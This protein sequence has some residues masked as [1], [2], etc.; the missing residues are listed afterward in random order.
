MIKCLLIILFSLSISPAFSNKNRL[1]LYRRVFEELNPYH[2]TQHKDS[3]VK[4]QSQNHLQFDYSWPAGSID[5]MTANYFYLSEF[6]SNA[7]ETPQQGLLTLE[8]LQGVSLQSFGYIKGKPLATPWAENCV[9]HP[10][11]SKQDAIRG[12]SLICLGQSKTFWI[13]SSYPLKVDWIERLYNE[14]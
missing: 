13:M 2:K 14:N 11:L 1:E 7:F 6:Q 4:Q 8:F 5:L 3:L 10:M 12:Y 9:H